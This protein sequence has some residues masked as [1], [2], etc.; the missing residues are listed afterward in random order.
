MSEHWTEEEQAIFD[1]VA[2]WPQVATILQILA[3][4]HG[5]DR[6][7]TEQAKRIL[8]ACFAGL[9]ADPEHDDATPHPN[10]IRH[11]LSDLTPGYGC[12]LDEIRAAIDNAAIPDEERAFLQGAL[13]M[14]AKFVY[15]LHRDKNGYA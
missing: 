1:T 5:Y 8:V 6:Q 7:A 14:A 15:A 3:D 4:E 11:Y 2:A 13:Y 10:T 9:L 12:W